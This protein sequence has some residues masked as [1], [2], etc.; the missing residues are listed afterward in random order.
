[1]VPRTIAILGSTGSVGTSTLKVAR[2][3]P[4]RFRVV[5]LAGGDNIQILSEQ[6]K[7]FRP[8]LVSTKTEDGMER[9]RSMVR[10]E[11]GITFAWGTQGAQQ[12]ASHPDAQ[13]VVSAIVGA[14]GLRPTLSAAESGKTI[15]LA[16]KESLVVA[17]ALVSKTVRKHGAKLLPVDSEHSAIFQ[18]LAGA[19]PQSIRRLIL[20]ASGGPFFRQPEKELSTVTPDEALAHPNWKMGSKITIDSATMMNKGL[21]IIEARWLFDLP[22]EKI[23]VVVHPQS[24][25]HSMVEYIDGSVIA[26]L[27]V[28]DMCGPI[29]YALSYPDR[30]D[31][32]VPSLDFAKIRELSFF[33]PDS[34]RFPL[35]D[36]AREALQKGETY[37][38]VLNGAN[39]VTVQAF[40]DRKIR[41]TDIPRIN[42]EVVSS[43]RQSSTEHL[44][45]YLNADSWGRTRAAELL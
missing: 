5:A 8:L 16:N 6:I 15:A 31:G 10:S 25:V 4:D 2:Q 19:T 45:D 41:F 24:I 40:L 26:Q 20:T 23:S 42:R 39:E 28:P 32:V 29:A 30:L 36:L 12:V 34:S 21:E 43:F 22:S 35:V 3:F 13:I 11:K 1:M 37:P 14:A 38:A 44:E 33:D 7:V 17:G 9:L 18:A 27:G